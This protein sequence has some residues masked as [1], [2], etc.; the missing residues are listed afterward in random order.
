[1]AKKISKEKS[2]DIKGKEYILVKDRVIFFNEEYPNG[3]IETNLI[4]EPTAEMVIVK[5]T[6]TP[7][8]DNPKRIFTGYSQA[9]WGDGYINKVSAMENC[10]TSAIGRALASMGIGVIDS[11]ASADEM[12]KSENAGP[13]EP[14][15]E[16]Q[17]NAIGI[18]L[19]KLG[20]PEEYVL[21]TKL[22]IGN[23]EVEVGKLD[24]RQASMVM[25]KMMDK[26]TKG[27]DFKKLV[28]GLEEPD[29]FE[30]LPELTKEDIDN[31]I[32]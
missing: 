14:A 17:I 30:K 13:T 2:I 9:T 25:G 7:N 1:M 12:R 27:E 29:P 8:V 21:E 22:R 24:K 23:K 16:K 6:I 26:K 31:G 19:K 20:Y 4:S 3:S 11:I 28:V 5:A 18:G 10:E 32:F 15:S